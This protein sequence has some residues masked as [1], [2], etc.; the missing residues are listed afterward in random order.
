ME[1]KEILEAVQS[2]VDAEELGY[3]GIQ[4]SDETKLEEICAD[5]LDFAT[6]LVETE[7]LTGAR[8]PDKEI[9]AIS[10]GKTVGDFISIVERYLA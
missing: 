6:L 7:K 3:R 5:S 8:I 1:R 4:V 2:V 10:K 9:E